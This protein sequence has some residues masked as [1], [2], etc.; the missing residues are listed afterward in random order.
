MTYLLFLKFLLQESQRN[1]EKTQK[2]LLQYFGRVFQVL[3]ETLTSKVV[4]APRK[5][6]QLVAGAQHLGKGSGHQQF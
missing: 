6:V 4:R 2:T 3:E 1:S 5:Q